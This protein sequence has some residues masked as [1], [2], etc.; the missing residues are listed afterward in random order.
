MLCLVVG[1]VLQLSF[2]FEQGIY[3]AQQVE[4]AKTL[5][6]S[7]RN[8]IQLK[9][10]ESLKSDASERCDSHRVSLSIDQDF[11][12][13]HTTTRHFVWLYSCL[14]R[15]QLRKLNMKTKLIT[16]QKTRKNTRDNSTRRVRNAKRKLTNQKA[17]MLK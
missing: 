13:H 7:Y 5:V 11:V 3:S 14:P 16:E 4:Q 9:V 8:F 10:N 6:D 17:T 15:S 1:T 12:F 2:S